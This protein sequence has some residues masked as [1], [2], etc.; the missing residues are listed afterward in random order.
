MSFSCVG[1]GDVTAVLYELA[2]LPGAPL[3]DLEFDP[4]VC[5]LRLRSVV[6]PLDFLTDGQVA[7]YGRFDGV[8]SWAD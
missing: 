5:L 7:A 8:P 4:G 6:V 2:W 1:C 3:V